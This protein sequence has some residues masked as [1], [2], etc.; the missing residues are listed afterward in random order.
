MKLHSDPQSSQ[1]T[2]TGYGIGFLEVNQTPYSY[3]LIV[4]PEGE[5]L[6]WPVKESQDLSEDHFSMISA[7][8]PELVIVGTGKKQV[9]LNPKILQPL[10]KAKIGFEMMDSQAACRTYNILMGEGRK[11]LA[12]ILLEKD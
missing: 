10:I 6:A 2:I 7:L 3:A 9:F 4:Q 11:V 1:N 12:A 5:V 8:L